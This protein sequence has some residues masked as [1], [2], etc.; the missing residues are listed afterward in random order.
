MA[1]SAFPSASVPE[2]LTT[3]QVADLLRE[4]GPNELPSSKARSR[5]ATGREVAREAMFLLL[6]ACGG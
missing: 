6:L 2:G 3:A 1:T 4:H 5:W